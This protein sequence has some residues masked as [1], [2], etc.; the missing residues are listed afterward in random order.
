MFGDKS[1]LYKLKVGAPVH[2]FKKEREQ[3]LKLLTAQGKVVEPTIG[4]LVRCESICTCEYQEKMIAMGAIKPKT[5]SDFSALKSGEVARSEHFKW[6]LGY[7]YTDEAE[8]GKGHSQRIIECLLDRFGNH[9]LMATTETVATNPMR[10]ILEKN[11]FVRC[12]K[13]WK[14]KIHEGELG[15]FLRYKKPDTR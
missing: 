12:G 3:L 9:N 1:N 15:L 8:R 6:E 13:T 2:F 7:M 14:S 4:K 10:H 5:N 11:G